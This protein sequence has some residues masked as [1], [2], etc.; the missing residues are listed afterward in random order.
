MSFSQPVQYPPAP[1]LHVVYLSV[2]LY[3]AHGVAQEPR[4]IYTEGSRPVLS[5]SL[6]YVGELQYE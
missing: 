5:L 1:D 3:M 4:R 6:A 2:S